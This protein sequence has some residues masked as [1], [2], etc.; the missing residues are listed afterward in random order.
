MD[1]IPRLL[2]FASASLLLLGF[3]TVEQG[4]QPA[5][6]TTT[7]VVAGGTSFSPATTTT[8]TTIATPTTTANDAMV[9]PTAR[10]GQWW[11]LATEAGWTEDLL[12]TLDYVLW[13]ESRCD[14]SQ[15]NTTRNED[16]STDIGL[17]QINDWSWCLPTRYYPDGYLQTI[18]ILT[19]VGC[20]QLFDPHTNLKAAKALY[21]Y[22]QEANGNGWQPWGL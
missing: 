16:G 1:F 12:E 6:G 20:E 3:E 19:T 10:C 7:T 14:P 17:T 4:Q 15:H 21:D 8:T 13:R 2:A 5:T 11:G 18:G 9:P 22:S